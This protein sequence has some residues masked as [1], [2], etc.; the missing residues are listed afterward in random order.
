MGAGFRRLAKDGRNGDGERAIVEGAGGEAGRRCGEDEA[1]ERTRAIK[2]GA[3][4]KR[5]IERGMALRGEQREIECGEPGARGE[6]GDGNHQH[7]NGALGGKER[8]SVGGGG[9][10]IYLV[11]SGLKVR[12]GGVKVNCVFRALVSAAGRG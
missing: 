12:K 9:H 4:S 8:A 6:F 1:A 2:R 5:P 7:Q 11:R 10:G 3:A